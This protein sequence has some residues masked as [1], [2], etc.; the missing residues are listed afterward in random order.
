VDE[1]QYGGGDRDMS[2]LTRYTQQVFGS[3]A[4]SNQM[5]EFGSLAAGTPAEYSGA[6]ITPTIVQALSNYID[7]WFAAV[8]GQNSPTIQDMNSLF[9]EVTYQLAYILQEG[10][11]EW[12]SGT[13][14]FT[15]SIVNASGILFKSLQDNN[16]NQAVTVAAYWAPVGGSIAFTAPTASSNYTVLST[17]S[18][19]SLSALSNTITATLPTAVGIRGKTYTLQKVDSS[20]HAITIATASSQTINGVVGATLNAQYE[21]LTIISDGANWQVIQAYVPAIIAS[22]TTSTVQALVSGVKTFEFENTVIDT[23]AGLSTT[24]SV[25][26]YTAAKAG[27]YL[28]T[29]NFTSN[30]AGSA[31][32]ICSLLYKNGSLFQLGNIC[33]YAVGN[34]NSFFITS[35][36]PMAVADY[37]TFGLYSATSTPCSIGSA[38]SAITG[39]TI[40]NN[41]Y[42]S[43][44]LIK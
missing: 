5:S 6:T 31:G 41:N 13:T 35:T 9:Y 36:V 25:T 21:D 44:Q 7:G 1:L 37:L 22:A 2:K 12:D 11:G 8:Q 28:V 26:R 42:L 19:V 34:N 18:Y 29:F 16:L 43:I 27:N 32:Q 33:E 20:T 17:D 23:V 14:Y 15:G 3:A 38:V 39:S 4:G 40:T 24:S 10:V 30:G